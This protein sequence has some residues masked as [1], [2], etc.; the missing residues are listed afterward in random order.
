MFTVF[1][2]GRVVPA[3]A[4]VTASAQPRVRGG[5]MSFN[6]ALQHLSSGLA[7]L[8]AGRII[9]QTETGALTRYWV[10]GLIAV[11]CTLVAIGISRRIKPVS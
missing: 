4:L 1:I 3:M 2:S 6:S 11:V 5:L 7:S 9:G 8:S 10:V